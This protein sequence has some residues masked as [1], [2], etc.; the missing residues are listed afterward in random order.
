MQT[1]RRSRACARRRPPRAAPRGPRPRPGAGAARAA[2]PDQ[3]PHDLAREV[4]VVVPVHERPRR[5]R[6][7]SG[8]VSATSLPN[9]AYVWI[10]TGSPAFVASA[11]HAVRRGVDPVPLE[12]A[13]ERLGM[14]ALQVRRG[15]LG[16]DR[17]RDPR[18]LLGRQRSRRAADPASARRPGGGSV[19]GS[20]AFALDLERPPR[21]AAASRR[22]RPR[23]SR[24][25][26]SDS[27][28]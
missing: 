24:S 23:S 2:S 21:A 10:A 18:G 20:S 1:R 11:T 26:G 9:P 25:A 16:A 6:P 17:R 13:L 12:D 14:D 28:E 19:G 22:A 7:A 4:R 15:P 3:E 8:R 27:A 5:A